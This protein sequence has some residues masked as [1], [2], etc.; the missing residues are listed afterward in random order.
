[1]FAERNELEQSELTGI[2]GFTFDQLSV[3][4]EALLHK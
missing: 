3:P 2:E 4:L 1:M